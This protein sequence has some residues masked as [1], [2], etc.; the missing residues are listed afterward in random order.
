MPET[1][2]HLLQDPDARQ[3]VIEAVC[4]L[5]KRWNLH[6]LNQA[7][8]LDLTDISELEQCKVSSDDSFVFVR[9]GYLLFIDRALLARYPYQAT[10]RDRWVWQSRKELHD[11]TPV[12]FMLHEGIEGIKHV[13]SMLD[14]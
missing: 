14:S 5:F 11:Q 9:I 1:W 3:V 10:T 12:A 2:L 7:G 8:L 4:A 13:R 6:P